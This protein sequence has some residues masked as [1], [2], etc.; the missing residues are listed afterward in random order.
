MSQVISPT[1]HWLIDRPGQRQTGKGE[2]K[3]SWTF[4]RTTQRASTS[5]LSSLCPLSAL[6]CSSLAPS[7][8]CNCQSDWWAKPCVVRSK[9]VWSWQDMASPAAF[10]GILSTCESRFR[11]S[12]GAAVHHLLQS[13]GLKNKVVCN[14]RKGRNETC[15]VQVEQEGPWNFTDWTRKKKETYRSLDEQRTINNLP[16]YN[17]PSI[18]FLYPLNPSVGSR[19]GLEPIPAVIGREAGYT[20]DR[21]PVHHRDTQRQTT[22]TATHAHIHP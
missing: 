18:H 2:T 4:I 19:G 10:K 17:Y 12:G 20:L 7:G 6:H 16:F 22:Q 5:L 8:Q 1:V 3:L 11:S 15:L 13:I 9:Q 14:L 21:S